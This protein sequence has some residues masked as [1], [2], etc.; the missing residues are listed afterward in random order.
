MTPKRFSLATVVAVAGFL[1]T[2]CG[3]DP[4]QGDIAI[5]LTDAPFPFEHV[6][7]TEVMID[8]VTVRIG[9]AGEG[10]GGFLTIDRTP[11][12]I[13]ILELRNGVV[14]AF[15]SATVPVGTVD[16]IRVYVGESTVTLVDDRFFD[17]VFP[18]GS[19]SGVKIFPDPPIQVVENE[20]VDVL[21][22]F[23]LSESFSSIPSSP[24]QVDDI[25]LFH[26]HPVLRAMSLTDVG[27]VS[28]RVFDDVGT[29]DPGDDVPLPGAA[30]FA[31]VGSDTTTSTSTDAAGRYVLMAL[32][33]GVV[34]VSAS[35]SGYDSASQDVAVEAAQETT[36]VDLLLTPSP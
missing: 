30:V 36:D 1:L 21:L 34:T 18:S 15:D 3:D 11:R 4:A 29:P 35:R 27:A 7:S 10:E 23:D 22:D 20:T 13:D 6:R 9:G 14:A 17:L 2:G 19:S 31:T 25:S 28:G 26:F 8:S 5:Y 16:Q 12:T 32:P 24:T 33:P